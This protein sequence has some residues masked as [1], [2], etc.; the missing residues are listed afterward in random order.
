MANVTLYHLGKFLRA[1]QV[2][3]GFLW[4]PTVSKPRIWY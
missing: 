1:Y 3:D 4:M 2:L